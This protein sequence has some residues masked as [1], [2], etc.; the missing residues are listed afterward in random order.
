M[1]FLLGLL[2]EFAAAHGQRAVNHHS[3]KIVRKGREVD[4]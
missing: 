4:S 2:T 1:N 3:Q